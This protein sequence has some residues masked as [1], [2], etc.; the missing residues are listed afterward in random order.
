MNTGT[1]IAASHTGFAAK[2]QHICTSKVYLQLRTNF[3]CLLIGPKI[4]DQAPLASFDRR[5]MHERKT[6]RPAILNM[7]DNIQ[8]AAKVLVT[9]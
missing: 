1:H 6:K 3:L 2:T 9:T 8:Q 4:R 7:A 5:Y